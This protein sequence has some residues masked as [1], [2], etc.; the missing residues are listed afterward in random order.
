MKIRTA[1]KILKSCAPFHGL[2]D[3]IVKP[4][5]YTERQKYKAY[6]TWFDRDKKYFKKHR[7]GIS[8]PFFPWGNLRD[9]YLIKK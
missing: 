9:D 1:K 4:S 3:L 2:I 6:C 8:R 5:R 7:P